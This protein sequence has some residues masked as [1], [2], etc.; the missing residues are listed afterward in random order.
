[1]RCTAIVKKQVP[2]I[3]CAKHLK[4]VMFSFIRVFSAKKS[5]KIFIL[6]FYGMIIGLLNG[7]FGGG[8]GIVCVPLLENVL[9]YDSKKAH[10]SAIAVILP[11]SLISASIYIFNG[12]VD[13]FPLLYTAIG[14]VFGGI[15]GAF[16]LKILPPKIVRILFA[17]IMLLGG[18]KLIL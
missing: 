17:I 5:K 2:K 10:A 8:G 12:F 3:K 13:F 14:V 9:K 15:I 16:T 6:L 11:L 1:M 4:K 18:I 7:F